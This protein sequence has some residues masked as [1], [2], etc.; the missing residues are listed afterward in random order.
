MPVNRHPIAI[1]PADRSS[2]RIPVDQAVIGRLR[3]SFAEVKGKDAD[4]GRIF[5]DALFA[6]AP[7]VRPLFK[8]DPESQSRKLVDSLEAVLTNL[9]NPV[10]NATMLAELGQRHVRYG[11]KPEHYGLVVSL[12]TDAIRQVLGAT[13][14]DTR[15]R[16][17]NLALTL[18]ARQMVAASS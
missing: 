3:S 10:E 7:Q 2:S 16:E 14:E 9:E 8:S 17:W 15:V 5:Y 4:L 13:N 6:A 1:I 18:I 12:L 11:A